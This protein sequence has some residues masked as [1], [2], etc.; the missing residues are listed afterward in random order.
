[1]ALIGKINMAQLLAGFVKHL[2]QNQRN[3][4]QQLEQAR[5]FGFGQRVKQMVLAYCVCNEH[6]YLPSRGATPANRKGSARYIARKTGFTMYVTAHSNPF[7]SPL[8]G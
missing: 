1:M 5:K 4:L 3:A 6:R 2:A 8:T 7:E